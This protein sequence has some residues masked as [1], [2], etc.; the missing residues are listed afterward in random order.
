[1]IEGYEI[2]LSC[3]PDEVEAIET[4]L[5]DQG[6][7]SVS[8]VDAA[9]QPLLEPGVGET[10]LWDDIT[11]CAYFPGDSKRLAQT[12][13]DQHAPV[14]TVHAVRQ[15]QWERAWMDNFKPMDFGRG[16][17]VVPTHQDPPPQAD[18][19]LRLDPGLAF[20]TGTH[21]TTSMCLKNLAKN[22]PRRQSVLDFGCGSGILAIAS[23]LLGASTVGAV[24]NDPQALLATAD[25]ARLNGVS[26]R[27]QVMDV[28]ESQQRFNLI[29]ANILANILIEYAPMLRQSL[30]A[31]GVLILSGILAEQRDSVVSAFAPLLIVD[32]TQQDEWIALT[33]GTPPC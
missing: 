2:R 13:A 23:A 14:G 6:A 10:P 15:R 16:L 33:L 22:P 19:I 20:G 3:V 18:V 26:D 32:Q 9:D 7:A 31:G 8:L 1:M 11:V 25:N 30:A 4:W 24:D 28:V 17:W 5:F 27:I 21:P 29:I 12:L